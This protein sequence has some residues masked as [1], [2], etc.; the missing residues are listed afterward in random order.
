MRG[1]FDGMERELHNGEGE[2]ATVSI[3][4]PAQTGPESD[5]YRCLISFRSSSETIDRKAY[6]LGEM[7]AM[8][9]GMKSLDGLIR[10]INSRLPVEKRWSW[11]GEMTPDDFGLP[12]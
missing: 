3:S 1:I 9:L 4:Y 12:R 10:T 8:F 2:M 7:Q 11:R 5:E 6:G